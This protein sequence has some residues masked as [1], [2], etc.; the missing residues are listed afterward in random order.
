M[1]I[2]IAEAAEAAS[3]AAEQ[4]GF[5][6]EP[7]TWVAITWIIVV[8]LLARPV[9]RAIAAALD[10]RREKIKARL[11]EAERLRVD[12]QETLA[13]YQRKQRE[14]LNEARDIIA[15]AKAEAERLAT[16]AAADLEVLVKRREQQAMERI[17]QAEAEAVREV[18]NL[19]V[20]IAIAATRKLLADTMSAD[21]AAA[22]IDAAIKDLPNRLH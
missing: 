18:R 21:K 22:L 2:A 7:E 9:Y 15:H 10:V 16:V 1:F 11:A 13:V 12:A 19:A 20:D 6:S 8:G 14:A 4:G 5:F 17:A 3:G